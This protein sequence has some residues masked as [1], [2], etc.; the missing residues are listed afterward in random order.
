MSLSSMKALLE[1]SCSCCTTV[2]YVALARV[3]RAK[4][5]LC[6]L[7]VSLLSGLS[8]YVA[9]CCCSHLVADALP[10]PLFFDGCFAVAATRSDALPPLLL[11]SPPIG[12][13]F[14]AKCRLPLL[15]MLCRFV[16]SSGCFGAV[17]C[18]SGCFTGT[19]LCL[20]FDGCLDIVVLVDTSPPLSCQPP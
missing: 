9:S 2:P 17:C 18:C 11:Q 7:Q 20:V 12:R 10:L 8:I 16:V 3:A 5:C 19:V 13:C 1:H 4:S 14:A 6:V 15:W